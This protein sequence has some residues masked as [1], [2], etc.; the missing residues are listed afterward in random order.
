VLLLIEEHSGSAAFCLF[1]VYYVDSV[2]YMIYRFK[3]KRIPQTYEISAFS[4]NTM[5]ITARLTAHWS[6]VK[7]RE[8]GNRPVLV[9]PQ[10]K[11]NLVASRRRHI[12]RIKILSHIYWKNSLYRTQILYREQ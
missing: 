3:R 8:R 5:E 9:I 11:Q 1:S 7:V 10:T 6:S 12:L 4:S 2:L